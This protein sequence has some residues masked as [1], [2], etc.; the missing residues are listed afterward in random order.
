MGFVEVAHADVFLPD[1]RLL[2]ADASFTASGSTTTALVGPNGA[3]KTTLLRLV[4]GELE[5]D[6]GT[7]VVNGK[8][9]VMP[10]FIGSIRDERTVRDLLVCLAP[11]A[12]RVAGE[13]LIAAE[14]AQHDHPGQS[15]DMGY[16]TAISE[17]GD[18]GGFG[19]EAFFGTRAHRPRFTGRTTRPPRGG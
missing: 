19:Y 17:W 10:Q 18:A 1:G 9:S 15:S 4:T 2:L 14:Q 11:P 16:A 6:S 3:G 5:P 13:A 8:L 12:L 7:V